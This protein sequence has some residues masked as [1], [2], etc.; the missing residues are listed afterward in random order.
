MTSVKTQAAI[1]IMNAHTR[2][3]GI[4]NVIELIDT[5]NQDLTV[6]EILD[7]TVEVVGAVDAEGYT[8]SDMIVAEEVLRYLKDT[9]AS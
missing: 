7:L 1:A 9:L 6:D 2:D 4:A 5:S 3:W 8:W